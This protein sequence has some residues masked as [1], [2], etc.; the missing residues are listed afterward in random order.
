M[1]LFSDGQSPAFHS[2]RPSS[3]LG[4]SMWNLWSTNSSWA[5]VDTVST[6]S[7]ILRIYSYIMAAT[8]K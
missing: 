5:G 3:I 8:S 1:F 2:G 6:T 4:Q 7:R